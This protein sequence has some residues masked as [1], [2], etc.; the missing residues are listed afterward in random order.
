MVP[1]AGFEPARPY[2]QW[3]LNPSCLP[4]HHPGQAVTPY[5]GGMRRLILVAAAVALVRGVLA[6]REKKLS[7]GEAD[8]GIV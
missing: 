3:I 8:L 7:E 5:P 4:F 6:Y 2:G 1:G